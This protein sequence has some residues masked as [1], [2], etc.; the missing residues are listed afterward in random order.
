MS[1]PD[2][3]RPKSSAVKRTAGG[4]YLVIALVLALATWGLMTAGFD[5]TFG[6]DGRETLEADRFEL[7]ATMLLLVLPALLIL[8]FTVYGLRMLITGRVGGE[9]R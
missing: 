3:L 6:L 5:G 7:C 9:D 2:L 4:V 8:L 1:I